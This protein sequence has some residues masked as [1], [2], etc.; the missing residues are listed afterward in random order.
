M[1]FTNLIKFYNKRPFGDLVKTLQIL[2]VSN[3]PVIYK[4]LRKYKLIFKKLSQTL[5]IGQTSNII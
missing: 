1:C 2:W 4:Q 5:K 3:Q